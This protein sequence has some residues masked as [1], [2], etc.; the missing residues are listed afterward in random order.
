[1]ARRWNHP[2]AEERGF[3]LVEVVVAL[4]ILS[5]ALLA[6]GKVQTAALNTGDQASRRS[7]A[8]GI[9]QDRIEQFQNIQTAAQFD[10]IADATA[11]ETVIVTNPVL[12]GPTRFTRNWVIL[13]DDEA[14]GWGTNV[15][16]VIVTVTWLGGQVNLRSLITRP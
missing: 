14:S 6:L 3:T 5:I 2:E 9:A 16:V 11:S 1:M 12:G 8:L 13:G 7:I 4:F 10:A 15:K